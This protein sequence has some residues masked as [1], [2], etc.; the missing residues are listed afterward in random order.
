[1]IHISN[2]KHITLYITVVK[3]EDEYNHALKAPLKG[4]HITW[5]ACPK[6]PTLCMLQCSWTCNFYKQCK[7]Q[8]SNFIINWVSIKHHKISLANKYYS[9]WIRVNMIFIFH[10]IKVTECFKMYKT[11]SEVVEWR[12]PQGCKAWLC[13]AEIQVVSSALRSLLQLFQNLN[14]IFA[15]LWY[16][17]STS[18]KLSNCLSCK[19]CV[20]RYSPSF[21]VYVRSPERVERKRSYLDTLSKLLRHKVAV[22][23]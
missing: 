17:F 21:R 1:M 8:V 22:I 2:W 7:L 19:T 10:F 23:T 5:F 11:N 13:Q 12:T 16:S 3:L 15:K 6:M 18:G 20:H 14:Q 9:L 4:I